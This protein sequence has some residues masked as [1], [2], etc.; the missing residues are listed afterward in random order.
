MSIARVNSITVIDFDHITVAAP[1]TSKHDRA[2]CGGG[3][4]SPPW[5]AKIKARVEGHL[6]RERIDPRAEIACSFEACAVHRRRQRHV[7]E[8]GEQRMKFLAMSAG[9]SIG[10]RETTFVNAAHAKI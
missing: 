3:D 10:L 7:R 2:R 8:S 9:C 4:G 6:V 1:R 5:A